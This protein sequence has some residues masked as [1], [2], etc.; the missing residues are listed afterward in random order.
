MPQVPQWHDASDSDVAEAHTTWIPYFQHSAAD[1][2]S[3]STVRHQ[4]R[5]N[6]NRGPWQ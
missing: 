2:W 1:Y 6:A 3:S 5:I 4:C